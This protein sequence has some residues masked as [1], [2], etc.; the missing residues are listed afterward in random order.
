MDGK[1][2]GKVRAFGLRAGARTVGGTGACVAGRVVIGLSLV[3]HCAGLAGA[4]VAALF[5]E[6]AA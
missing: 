2:D 3:C 5:G 4:D 1:T 6:W